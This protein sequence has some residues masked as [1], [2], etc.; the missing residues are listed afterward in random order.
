MGKPL[1]AY[2]VLEADENTGGITFARDKRQALRDGASRWHSGEPEYCEATRAPWAD[3][4]AESG[5]IPAKEMIANGWHLECYGCGAR[6]DE[7]WLLDQGLPLSGVIGS[8]DSRTYCC[9]RCKWRHMKRTATRRTQEELAIAA[10]KNF[11][12]RRFPDAIF[13]PNDKS[14]AY[15]V[16]GP[17]GGWHWQEVTVYFAFPGMQIGP[18]SCDLR[19]DFG[20]QLLPIKPVFRCYAGD[21]EAF[22][23]WAS[24]GRLALAQEGEKK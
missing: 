4:F 6:I 15:V 10:V 18:A 12:L 13:R 14:H 20:R 3:R 1:R 16:P 7:D 22:E 9:A 8:Q 11:V 23:A 19:R 17:H 2:A 21:K 24:A 5:E